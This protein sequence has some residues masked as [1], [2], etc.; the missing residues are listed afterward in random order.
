MRNEYIVSYR[1]NIARLKQKDSLRHCLIKQYVPQ[2][3]EVVLV[4]QGFCW[5]SQFSGGIREGEGKMRSR[6]FIFEGGGV[7]LNK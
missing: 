2:S 5:F 3:L 1:Y 7:P 4:K 6:A